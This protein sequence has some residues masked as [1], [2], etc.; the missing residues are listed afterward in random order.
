MVNPLISRSCSIMIDQVNPFDQSFNHNSQFPSYFP[1]AH[2]REKQVW[3]SSKCRLRARLPNRL[4]KRF[5]WGNY[6]VDGA[7]STSMTSQ[8]TWQNCLPT[9][10]P[11]YFLAAR[12]SKQDSAQVGVLVPSSICTTTIP[13]TFHAGNHKNSYKFALFSLRTWRLPFP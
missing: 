7:V 6:S 11:F 1:V 13:L 4:V 12:R 9:F 10:Q 8:Q 3:R 2:S 5:W